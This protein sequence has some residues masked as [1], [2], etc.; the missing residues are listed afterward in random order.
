MLL[1]GDIGGTKSDL[2][3]V[4]PQRGPRHPVI[5]QTLPSGDYPSL[6]ALVRD[7]LSR[8]DQPVEYAS[9]G[10]AGPIVAGRVT[11]TNLSWDIDQ[12][13]L[14]R[15]LNFRS[16][17]LLN[18]L[19]SIAYA[20]PMLQPDDVY[21]LNPGVPVPKGAIAV[22]APGTGLGE[23]Y[24]TWEGAGYRAR[25]SEGGHADFAPNTPLER[26]LLNYLADRYGHVSYERACSGLGLP[27]LYAYLK[28]IGYAEEPAWFTDQLSQARDLTP[29]IVNNALDP[30][31]R[32]PL[33]TATLDTFASVLASEAGNLALR[34]MA[35]GGVYIA[36]GIPPRILPALQPERFMRAFCNKGR[37]S[38]LMPSIP[39]HVVLNPKT[40]L[41]GA[42]FHGLAMLE[43]SIG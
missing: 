20:I 39:V 35:T 12:A 15:A 41:L 10:V 32:C 42:A 22:I 11:I 26:G 33:C 3:V 43:S 6:E 7:F 40:P 23:A 31:S 19:E 5:E 18:D 13:Q 9:L 4:H 14:Q 34:V 36:G 38:D 16:V 25:P 24:L 27:N 1:A 2:A 29:L 28:Q 37:L 21:T 8:V 17:Y 30:E